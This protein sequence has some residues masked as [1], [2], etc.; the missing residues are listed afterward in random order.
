MSSIIMT[1]P[2]KDEAQADTV[3]VKWSQQGPVVALRILGGK[4][5]FVNDET[6]DHTVMTVRRSST[7]HEEC[8]TL[9]GTLSIDDMIDRFVDDEH[10]VVAYI[11]RA[12]SNSWP[13]LL[14]TPGKHPRV[15][16]DWSKW[17]PQ[18]ASDASDENDD[19]DDDNRINDHAFHGGHV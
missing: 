7:G 1:T 17:A 14:A 13:R 15:S 11:T 6:G 16:V 2:N 19:D 8:F 4:A 5:T 9:F 12:I 18:D 10:T 3:L